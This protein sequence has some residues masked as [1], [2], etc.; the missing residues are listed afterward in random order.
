MNRKH[1]TT[2]FLVTLEAPAEVDPIRVL[3]AAL[4]T[5]LRRFGLKCLSVR[6]LTPPT[7]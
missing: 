1:P 7:K 4:K 6:E 3:R 5:L 2:K